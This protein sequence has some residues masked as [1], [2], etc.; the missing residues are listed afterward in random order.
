MS[1]CG[2]TM[3]D[4]ELWIG[5]E[6]GASP[7]GAS[8]PRVIAAP[9]GKLFKGI[10]FDG[11]HLWVVCR[12]W[13]AEPDIYTIRKHTTS[14]DLLAEY[15]AP[16]YSY[17]ITWDGNNLWVSDGASLHKVDSSDGQ[18]VAT[19]SLVGHSTNFDIAWDGESIWIST[20]GGL[21]S[22]SPPD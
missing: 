11:N 19:Y 12:D 10:T 20:S 3:V 6:C 16:N 15:T 21:L 8:W 13:V 2:L 7:E 18:V 17:G 14:G 5:M 9:E 1:V 22:W 4:D